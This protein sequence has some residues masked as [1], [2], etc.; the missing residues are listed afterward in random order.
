MRNSQRCDAVVTASSSCTPKRRVMRGARDTGAAPGFAGFTMACA[1]ALAILPMAGHAA[2][3]AAPFRTKVEKWVEARQLVSEERAEWAAEQQTLRATRDLLRDQK[4]IL[5]DQIAEL[6]SVDTQ[7]DETRRTLLLE[8]GELQRSRR[9]LEERVTM[10]EKQVLDLEPRLPAPLRK[11]LEPLVVQIPRDPENTRISLGQRLVSVLGILSQTEKFN[12]TATFVAETRAVEG[13]TKIQVRTL[14]WG[15]GQ[16][17]YVDTQGR[18]AGVGRPGDDGWIF[19]GEGE[20]AEDAA[21]LLDIY[22]GNTDVI[23]FVEFPVAVQ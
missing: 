8:R 4:Q 5:A 3:G 7:A 11:K 10:L 2:E 9:A 19:T 13:D 21:L 16:A 17:L 15:L 12:D 22:E 14:Y 20:I 23:D 6:E 1:A 18:L